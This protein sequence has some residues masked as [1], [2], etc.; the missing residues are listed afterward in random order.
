MN[1]HVHV[2]GVQDVNNYAKHL[3]NKNITIYDLLTHLYHMLRSQEYFLN[4]V[5]ECFV[6]LLLLL[7]K[8]ILQI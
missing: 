6:L 3:V 5:K 7:Q 4:D 2:V 8:H 1:I